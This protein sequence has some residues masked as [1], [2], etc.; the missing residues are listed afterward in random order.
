MIHNTPKQWRG[1]STPGK[2]HHSSIKKHCILATNVCIGLVPKPTERLN[3]LNQILNLLC[4]LSSIFFITNSSSS[5]LLSNTPLIWVSIIERLN[6][7]NIFVVSQYSIYVPAWHRLMILVY[8][9]IINHYCLNKIW[10]FKNYITVQ[11]YY[12]RFHSLLP[13]I[14]SKSKIGIQKLVFSIPLQFR[15]IYK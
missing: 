6:S 14:I 12:W 1:W 13:N 3:S 11:P 7:L 15:T 10:I 4:I 2:I 9:I 8:T 5:I